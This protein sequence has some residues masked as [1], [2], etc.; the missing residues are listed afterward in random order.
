MFLPPLQQNLYF[1]SIK[2]LL[3]P[4]LWKFRWFV[5]FEEENSDDNDDAVCKP[6][7]LFLETNNI[8]RVG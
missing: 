4:Q 8:Q 1:F 6:A 5:P 2:S 3:T 7:V